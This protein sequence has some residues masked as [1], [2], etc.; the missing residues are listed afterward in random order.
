MLKL[1]TLSLVLCLGL[2]GSAFSAIN[3]TT[4][5]DL[6]F[7]TIGPSTGET[8]TTADFSVNP[9]GSTDVHGTPGIFFGGDSR[10]RFQVTVG[11]GNND[12]PLKIEVS[13]YAIGPYLLTVRPRLTRESTTRLTCAKKSQ[14]QMRQIWC[15][16]KSGNGTHQV[17]F[18]VGGK[19]AKLQSGWVSGS[20]TG[21][22]AITAVKDAGVCP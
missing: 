8:T 10:G 14:T 4:L 7:G 13:G 17:T 15:C 5:D 16:E 19:R 12:Y 1:K 22:M 6:D 3:I 18:W 2:F 9:N 21:S 20:Y 11:N